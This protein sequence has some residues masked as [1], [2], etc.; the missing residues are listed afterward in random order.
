MFSHMGRPAF[1]LSSDQLELLLAFEDSK[2]LAA[3]AESM[4]RDP[5]VISRGL[6]R[7]A[8]EHPVLV[9]VRGKWELTPLGRETNELTRNSIA[10]YKSLLSKTAQSQKPKKYSSNKSLL[11]IVNAQVGLLD[12]TQ[13]GRNNSDAEKNISNLLNHWRKN[14]RPVVHV[15]HVSDNPSSMFF[16]SSAGS[17]IL[18]E[19]LPLAGE[20]IL[21]KTKS[22]AFTETSLENQLKQLEPEEILLV[23]FTANECIDA[24]ARD[25]STLGF[26]SYVVGDATA[27]FDVRDPLGK[28]M[29]A[30]RVHKLTLANINAFYAKVIQTSEV[31]D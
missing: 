17:E 2:G 8:E 13:L 29:K 14:K 18:P 5:S 22:S 7:I 19:L 23:G 6:L 3:L 27:M 21:E 4:G 30:E 25:A 9:K 16:R 26:T 1:L 24:T 28:L 12:A 11:L 20:L 15:K 31:M 10:S